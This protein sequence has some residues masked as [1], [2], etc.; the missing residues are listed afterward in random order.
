MMQKI[1][2]AK[3]NKPKQNS[4]IHC[5]KMSRTQE[6]ESLKWQEKSNVLKYIENR[7]FIQKFPNETLNIRRK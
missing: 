3:Q 4:K 2:S 7:K 5:I 6:V 1:Q